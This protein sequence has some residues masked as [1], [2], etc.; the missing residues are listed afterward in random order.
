MKRRGQS[1][2]DVSKIVYVTMQDL[3]RLFKVKGNAKNCTPSKGKVL[4]VEKGV[5]SQIYTVIVL[6]TL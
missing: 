1:A 6:C 2:E 3:L 5:D 4:L